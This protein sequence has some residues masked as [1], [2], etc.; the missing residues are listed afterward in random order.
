MI[1]EVNE[2]SLKIGL[3]LPL[4]ES[5]DPDFVRN[6]VIKMK[7]Y[8]VYSHTISLANNQTIG[9]APYSWEE[10]CPGSEK[11]PLPWETFIATLAEVGY[12]GLLSHEQCSPIIIKGHKLGGVDTVDERYVEARNFFRPLLDK[13]NAYEGKSPV[14][15]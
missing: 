5:N 15:I 14:H 6:I 4:L 12:K 10:V 9:G 3:D 2:S 1:E 11:D 13:Y 8:M 7:D